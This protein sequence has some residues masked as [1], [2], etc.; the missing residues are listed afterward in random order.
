[1]FEVQ[2]ATDLLPPPCD[3]LRSKESH[4]IHQRDNLLEMR[5]ST[6]HDLTSLSPSSLSAASS[7]FFLF[8]III[9][10]F[11][12]SSFSYC[13]IPFVDITATFSF[14]SFIPSLFLA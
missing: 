10:A 3:N 11:A 1:M 9:I 4:T 5:L 12:V 7:A 8:S 13:C 14:T 2:V 6:L